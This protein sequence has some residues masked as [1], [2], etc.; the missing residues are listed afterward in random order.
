MG[1]EMNEWEPLLH[2]LAEVPRENGTAALEQTAWFLSD[3][4]SGAGFEALV[5]PFP[6]EPFVLRL[7][8]VAA[9]AIG[10]FYFLKL[11]HDRAGTAFLIALLGVG[12]ILAQLEYHVPIFGWI[13][14]K[15]EHNI[16]ARLAPEGEPEQ[17]ILL[18]AHYDTKTDLLDHVERFP[19]DALALPVMGLMLL[20]P[21]LW[22]MLRRR[23]PRAARI[24]T[25]VTAWFALVF[26]VAIFAV[27][28]GGVFV[29]KRSPGAIDDGA[30]CAVLV[31]MAEVLAQGPPLQRTEVVV[32]LLSGEEINLQGSR[33]YARTRFLE[34][35][36]LP[37]YLVNL[38][39]L[40]ASAE[41]AVAGREA[42]S[43]SG[44]APDAR[45]LALLD[46]VHQRLYGKALRVSTMG[47]RTDAFSFL[48]RGIPALTLFSRVDPWWVPRHL[49][50]ADDNRARLDLA[51][52]GDARDYLVEVVRSFDAE[53]L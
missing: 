45:L 14:A 26:C 13:G 39:P 15:T 11:R 50:S 53:S 9:L 22:A 46:R 25:S 6:A 38:D 37:S 32:L 20:S 23:R 17:R 24:L 35:P 21:L 42:S 29:A 44:Y 41:L 16:E 12:A 2:E 8:G 18:A 52:L 48:D 7:L 49:H 5:H 31:R 19:V 34:L 4:L 40:G 1:A 27:L 33:H 10:L 3:A 30:A 36:V 28:S 51:S 43:L 47:G